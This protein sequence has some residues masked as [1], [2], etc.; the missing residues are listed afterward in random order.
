M[1]AQAVADEEYASKKS[2][3]LAAN[4][5]ITF[6]DTTKAEERITKLTDKTFTDL[7]IYT[8]TAN[9]YDIGGMSVKFDGVT[10]TLNG[11]SAMNDTGWVID[12]STSGSNPS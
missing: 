3:T 9:K 8:K 4:A 12:E 1:A 5:E 7:H 2:V 10:A 6:A 11:G